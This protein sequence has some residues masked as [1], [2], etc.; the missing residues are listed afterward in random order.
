VYS[1]LSPE[2]NA[3]VRPASTRFVIGLQSPPV[4]HRIDLYGSRSVEEAGWGHEDLVTLDY[5][6]VCLGPR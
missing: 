1:I 4:P 5:L 2:W 3:E 6:Q